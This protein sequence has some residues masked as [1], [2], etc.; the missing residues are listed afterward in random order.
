M[1]SVAV[2]PSIL[3]RSSLASTMYFYVDVHL[4]RQRSAHARAGERISL[5]PS[6]QHSLTAR[7]HEEEVPVKHYEGDSVTDQPEFDEVEPFSF[8]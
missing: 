5:D 6:A 2:H 3:P 4:S 7:F 1:D 8:A